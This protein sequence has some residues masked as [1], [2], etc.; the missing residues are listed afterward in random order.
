MVVSVTNKVR[1]FLTR[2]GNC[3]ITPHWLGWSFQDYLG[4]LVSFLR[5]PSTVIIRLPPRD[6]ERGRAE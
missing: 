5:F 4:Y 2:L 6:D 1:L 3:F